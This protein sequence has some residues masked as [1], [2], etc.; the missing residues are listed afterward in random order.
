MFS[1]GT[2]GDGNT[3]IE[4]PDKPYY[5]KRPHQKSRKG[6]RNCKKRK[7][8]CDEGRPFCKNCRV[9]GDACAYLDPSAAAA[10]S[11][12]S[13][14]SAPVTSPG[15][16]SSSLAPRSPAESTLIHSRPSFSPSPQ[17]AYDP[18]GFSFN[19]LSSPTTAANAVA[20]VDEPLFIPEGR[21]VTDL[22][23]LWFY[24]RVTYTSFNTNAGRAHPIDQVLQVKIVEHA[25]S[26]PFLM[27]CVLGLSAMHIQHL[28]QTSLMKISPM[29]TNF[30]RATAIEGYRKAIQAADP[31]SFPA[32][33]ACSLLLTALVSGAFRE[34]EHYTP[35]YV[36]DWINV[37]RGIGAIIELTRPAA[38]YQ[39]GLEML[40]FRPPINLDASARHVPGNLLFMV[41]RIRPG[42]EDEPYTEVYYE[43]LKYLGS[44]Y[45]ELLNG[46]S[47]ILDLRIV[48]FY[49]FLPSVF[50]ELARKKRPRA[51]IIVAHHLAFTK[52]IGHVWWMEGISDREIRNIS[53]TIGPRWRSEINVPMIAAALTDKEAICKL[54]LDN[55]YWQPPPGD[56]F[57]KDRD[58]RA[59]EL[60]FVD[61][62]GRTVGFVQEAERF[63][64]SPSSSSD[65]SSE[66]H[67]DADPRWT[68]RSLTDSLH[69]VGQMMPE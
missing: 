6:C 24:S 50:I 18:D 8:K 23:L 45:G 57:G 30:Y 67:S 56:K 28:G 13:S 48:T 33:L 20:V 22:K 34:D 42:D 41:T 49:T 7:V 52:L 17:A 9:R 10:L 61:D 35:L 27:N 65:S 66:T 19:D 51:L 68:L 32:L 31:Q 15:P 12:S 36:L 63:V 64:L 69:V 3:A 25:F 46:F 54:L 26:S 21:N 2:S 11:S 43:T 62:E 5:P 59:K 4:R 44:L 29:V 58:P 53:N 37:W 60:A 47:P 14:S 1:T 16:G 55:H 38:M 40:F 39:S